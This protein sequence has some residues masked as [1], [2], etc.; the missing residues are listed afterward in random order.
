M[1]QEQ[2]TVPKPNIK[3]YRLKK[4]KRWE[5]ATLEE[6]IVAHTK[7]QSGEIDISKEPMR[8]ESTGVKKSVHI[9]EKVEDPRTDNSLVKSLRV[10]RFMVEALKDVMVQG[11]LKSNEDEVSFFRQVYSTSNITA[12]EL[13]YLM[14]DKES[15]VKYYLRRYGI[16]KLPK[17]ALVNIDSVDKLLT[18]LRKPLFKM[19][20][21]PTDETPEEFRERYNSLAFKAFDKVE[22]IITFGE[23]KKDEVKNLQSAISALGSIMKVEMEAKTLLD[24]KSAKQNELK[25]K[26]INKNAPKE[27]TV[28][29][30]NGDIDA[31][32][33]F[34]AIRGTFEKGTDMDN[35]AIEK[36][37]IDVTHSITENLEGQNDSQ[38]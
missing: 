14:D 11:V 13:A 38:N 6:L 18:F 23:S 17:N 29:N 36:L 28:I 15:S 35:E 12:N 2:Q 34:L 30:F 7:I 20:K 10:R 3:Y 9:D 16:V 1:K 31:Q 32:D 25:E 26:E 27:T 19:V 37:M 4:Y 8:K 33:L 24:V 22:N 5:N 21:A